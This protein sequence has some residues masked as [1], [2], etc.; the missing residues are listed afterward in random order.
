ML[1][2]LGVLVNRKKKK[3]AAQ[4]VVFP[5]SIIQENNIFVIKNSKIFDLTIFL[6]LF[7]YEAGLKFKNRKRGWK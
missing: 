3:F 1:H 7:Q 2:I 6:C 4:G 5:F